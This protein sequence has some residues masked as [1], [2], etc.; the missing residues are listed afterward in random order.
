MCGSGEDEFLFWA[1]DP[2]LPPPRNMR[3]AWTP[4]KAGSA[5]PTPTT[6]ILKAPERCPCRLIAMP[7]AAAPASISPP[8]GM[9]EKRCVIPDEVVGACARAEGAWDQAPD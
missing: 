3:P 1:E 8:A 2:R 7:A 9:S 5:M 6:R 4:H